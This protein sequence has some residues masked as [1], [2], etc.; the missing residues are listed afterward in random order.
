M[1][2]FDDVRGKL[3]LD[4][5]FNED[6][7]ASIMIKAPYHSGFFAINAREARKMAAELS[8]LAD[9]QESWEEGG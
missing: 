4:H 2:I 8:D 9:A 6:N 7:N 1:I 5:E 3:E